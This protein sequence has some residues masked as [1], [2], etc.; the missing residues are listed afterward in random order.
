MVYTGR[1]FPRSFVLHCE[2][3]RARDGKGIGI[4]LAVI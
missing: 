3:F 4:S 1:W 2:A